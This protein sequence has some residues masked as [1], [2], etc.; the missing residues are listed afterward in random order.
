MMYLQGVP[1]YGVDC[2]TFEIG[3]ILPFAKSG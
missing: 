3:A 1:Q 2:L